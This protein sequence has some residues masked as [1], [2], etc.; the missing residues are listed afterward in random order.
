[1]QDLG[2]D[3]TFLNYPSIN[4]SKISG[5]LSRRYP[6]PRLAILHVIHE[7]QALKIAASPCLV[8]FVGAGTGLVIQGVAL[9]SRAR[10]V[11]QDMS[12]KD[13]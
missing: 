3:S 10:H 9:K 7:K 11:A 2:R 5:M 12:S 8:G 6:Q 1:M 4:M 13:S